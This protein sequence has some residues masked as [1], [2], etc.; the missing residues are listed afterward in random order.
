MTPIPWPC[1]SCGITSGWATHLLHLSAGCP[2][3]LELLRGA[4]SWTAAVLA[5]LRE[6]RLRRWREGVPCRTWLETMVTHGFSHFLGW[7]LHPGDQPQL[8]LFTFGSFLDH[9]WI[10]DLGSFW[11]LKQPS[12]QKLPPFRQAACASRYR[13]CRLRRG[14]PAVG[15]AAAA[16][17]SSGGSLWELRLACGSYATGRAVHWV[18]L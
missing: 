15:L 5:R 11:D 9:F 16:L 18:D 4:E 3:Q 12:H 1:G 2:V 7:W 17:G 14:G 8:T 6:D 10:T 13:R